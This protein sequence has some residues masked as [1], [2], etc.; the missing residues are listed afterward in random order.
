MILLLRTDART[1]PKKWVRDILRRHDENA[2]GRGMEWK[3]EEDDGKMKR[4]RQDCLVLRSSSLVRFLLSTGRS[5]AVTSEGMASLEMAPGTSHK[6]FVLKMT[7]YSSFFLIPYPCDPV[8]RVFFQT[9][10]LK[11]TMT[12]KKTR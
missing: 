1:R 7:S 4:G 5:E 8:S 10:C 3:D 11:S 6:R 12:M 9:S 2:S